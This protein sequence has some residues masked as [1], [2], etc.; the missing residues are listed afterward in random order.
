MN[1]FHQADAFQT[2]TCLSYRYFTVNWKLYRV[3]DHDFVRVCGSWNKRFG[4]HIKHKDH[5]CLKSWINKL[6]TKAES[7]R[8]SLKYPNLKTFYSE[9]IK[10][11]LR[12]VAVFE[13]FHCNIELFLANI[14]SIDWR[15]WIFDATK[16]CSV[17][18]FKPT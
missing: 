13:L 1:E 8:L 2:Q 18:H 9:W 11:Y 6:D 12:C 15:L 10:L 4:I 7:N 14:T 16:I 5:K 17:V 3:A